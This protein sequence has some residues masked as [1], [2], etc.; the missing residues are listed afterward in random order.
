[1]KDRHPR[2]TEEKGGILT[3]GIADSTIRFKSKGEQNDKRTTVNDE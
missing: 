3:E 2:R 1:M